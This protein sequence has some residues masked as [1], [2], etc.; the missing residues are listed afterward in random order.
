MKFIV[1]PNIHHTF[2]ALKFHDVYPNSF[3][4]GTRG[5]LNNENFSERLHGFFTDEGLELNANNRTERFVVSLWPTD[6][7]EFFCFYSVPFFD[8]IVFYHR[9]SSTLI[10]TDLA[11][12]Y[13]EI[14]ENPVRAEGQLFRFYLWLADGYRV[15][16]VTKPFRYFFRKNI[17]QVRSDF[18]QL[19]NRYNNFQR[20]IMAHGTVIE[21]NGYESLSSGTYRFVVDLSKDEKQ[22]KPSYSTVRF[23]FLVVVGGAVL[24]LISKYI[25]TKY[26]SDFY[27]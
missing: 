26:L 4:I 19:M 20:L 9:P 11:F 24:F 5:V 27:A 7:I 21:Q 8:E 16:N 12:N 14:G 22:R 6:E 18:D 15:A 13:S 23:G 17:D 10:V 2:W 1:V 3:L 25:N